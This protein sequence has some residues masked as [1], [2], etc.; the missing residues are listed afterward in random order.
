MQVASMHFKERA[1]VNLDDARLQ[2][3]LE[4]MRDNLDVWLEIF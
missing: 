4:R 3:N 1:R 2:M